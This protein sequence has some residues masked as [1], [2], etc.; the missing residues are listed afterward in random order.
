MA[1]RTL[2]KDRA[3]RQAQRSRRQVP[4]PDGLGLRPV[5]SPSGDQRNLNTLSAKFLLQ[6]EAPVY[7]HAAQGFGGMGGG[8]V[9][10]PRGGHRYPVGPREWLPIGMCAQGDL[11]QIS[12]FVC[13]NSH[14][15]YCQLIF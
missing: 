15:E 10:H 6:N 5:L 1:K 13:E 14:F 2:G 9:V 12:R 8:A 3:G 4:K 11:P 7:C